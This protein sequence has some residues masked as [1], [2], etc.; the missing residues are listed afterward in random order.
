MQRRP[1]GE[2]GMTGVD[3]Y[4][5]KLEKRWAAKEK[6][7]AVRRVPILHARAPL[8]HCKWCSKEVLYPAGHKK[9]GQRNERKGWHDTCL[10]D[11]FLHSRPEA[12]RSFLIRRDGEKCAQCGAAPLK[13]VQGGE[14][15]VWDSK[16]PRG[17]P[18]VTYC[19]IDIRINLHIEHK[20]P[21]WKIRHLPDAERVKFFG[22]GNLQLLCTGLDCHGG[23]TKAEAAERAHFDRMADPKEPKF[24]RK[25][26]SPCFRKDITR[27]F[28]GK[29][30]PRKTKGATRGG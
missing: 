18:P 30:K 23:K 7:D 4:T 11:F 8:G 13:V 28:G 15:V 6:R 14:V 24:K 26:Q 3:D 12:Q 29:V 10:G 5:T 19:E 20:V 16:R 2:G 1:D 17:E 22:P 27:T 9:A 21:L 25:I